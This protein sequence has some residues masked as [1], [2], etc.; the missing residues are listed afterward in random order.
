MALAQTA[1]PGEPTEVKG[2]VAQYSMTPRGAVEGLIMVDG[3]EVLMS[4]HLSTQLVFAVR[5]GDAVTVQGMKTVANPVVTAVSLTNDVTGAVVDA[6][7]PGPAQPLDDE[8]RVKLQLHDPDGRLNGVLLEDGAIVRMPSPDADA[9]AAGLAVGQPLY[10]RREGVTTPL[11]KVI[12]ARE[13]GP[14][15]TKLIKVDQSRFERWKS[16]LFG[17]TSAAAPSIA[18]PLAAVTSPPIATKT[19]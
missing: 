19:P 12:A 1:P 5:P 4:P 15:K 18:T 9:D 11:G 10:A 2:K 3:T 16:D 14:A 8:S 13:I 7:P 6:R 17:A